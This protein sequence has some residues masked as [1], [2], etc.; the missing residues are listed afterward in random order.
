MSS[1]TTQVLYSHSA[2]TDS[3]HFTVP[4]PHEPDGEGLFSLAIEK[5][6]CIL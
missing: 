4:Q 6:K 3:I 1:Q 2:Q 5:F